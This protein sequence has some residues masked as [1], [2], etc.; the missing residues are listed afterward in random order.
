MKSLY[1][2]AVRR[3]CAGSLLVFLGTCVAEAQQQQGQQALQAFSTIGGLIRSFNANIVQGL[4]TLALSAAVVVFF[5]GIVEYIW[6]VRSG[7]AGK[8][9]TGNTFMVWGLVGLFVMFS[10]W[11]IIYFAQSIFGIQGYT[12]QQVMEGRT[13]NPNQNTSPLD[14]SG[15]VIIPVRNS[16]GNMNGFDVPVTGSDSSGAVPVTGGGASSVTKCIGKAVGDSCGA[17]FTC[18]MTETDTFQCVKSPTVNYTPPPQSPVQSSTAPP[19]DPAQ[20][21]LGDAQGP[22]AVTTKTFSF[23]TSGPPLTPADGASSCDG[24]Y[25][26]MECGVSMRCAYTR[27]PAFTSDNSLPLNV[28]RCFRA[29]D[30]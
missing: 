4:G 23:T 27:N 9:K 26:G 25:A 16:V 30:R 1:T 18:Q 22:G 19:S 13:Q 21:S 2:S 6:G 5:F 11:G 17:G 24:G 3:I 29:Q 12:A 10:V 15:A 14:P 28:L 20:G 7:D 8:T